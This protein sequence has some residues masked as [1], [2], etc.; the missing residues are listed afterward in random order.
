M[1]E[2]KQQTISQAAESFLEMTKLSRSEN[3][4][5]S[6]KNAIKVFLSVLEENHLDPE[7]TSVTQLTEGAISWLLIAL[8]A[9]APASEQL[10]STAVSRFYQFLIAEDLAQVNLQ[11]LQLIVRNR[12]RKP[13]QRLPQFPKGDLEKII[14]YAQELPRFNFPS[15]SEKLIALRDSALILS[16]ADTG[17]RAHEIC[18]LRRGDVD[19]NEYKAII[20]GKGNKQAVIRFSSRSIDATKSY[21]N[22]RANQDGG[23]GRP[24]AALP[25]FARHDKGAGKKTLP[26]STTT[27]R[28]IIKLRTKEIL[29]DQAAMGISPHTFR[30]YFV[31]NVLIGSGGNMKLAQE[32]AR[33]KSIQVTQRYTHLSDDELDKGYYQIFDE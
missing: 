13:G 9:Y 33:H 32:L 26:I 27:A 29:G 8:K 7:K 6:Y 19:W 16:L 24:L 20:I 25:V 17:M 28:N 21:L 4:F 1:A 10:Y 22:Q 31:T 14:A 3:T 30:H 5:R 11:K 15:E 12:S 2:Q 23:T 18:N